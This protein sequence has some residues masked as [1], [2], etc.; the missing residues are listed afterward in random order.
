MAS[1]IRG[2]RSAEA[3]AGHPR[4]AAVRPP[5]PAR[6]TVIIAGNGLE[7]QNRAASELPLDATR[8]TDDGHPPPLIHSGRRARRLHAVSSRVRG[9]PSRRRTSGQGITADQW[10]RV[11][12]YLNDHR[13]ELT[14]A[15]AELY[16]GVDRVAPTPLQSPADWRLSAPVSLTDVSLRWDPTAPP[17]RVDGTEPQSQAVRPVASGGRRLVDYAEALAELDPP[18]L[19]ENRTCYRLTGVSLR[20]GARLT[21]GVSTYFAGLS[22]GEAAAHEFAAWHM[23]R[24]ARPRLADLPFRDLAGHPADLAGRA[25]NP[26]ISMLTLRRERDGRSTFLLHHRDAAQVAHGGGLYQVIPVGVFQPSRDTSAALRADFDLWRCAAR[27]Y[28][29]ELLGGAETY[30]EGGEGSAAF[31]YEAWPFYRSLASARAAGMIRSYLLGL[32]VDPLSLATDILAVTVIDG[33]AFDE[34]FAALAARNAEGAIA[35]GAGGATGFAFT[36]AN[37]ERF[38]GREPMQAAG[39]AVLTLAW[40]YRG[41]LTTGQQ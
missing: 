41:Q 2:S 35:G 10:R 7:D 25:V 5:P 11:R 20:G 14:S 31:D 6:R 32:G 9:V 26:A 12:R 21:F 17:A 15:A 8:N 13:Y 34:I 36:Q 28:S 19:L 24:P 22:V 40:R 29:E 1:R 37:V 23:N 38:A 27:E 16:P 39:A 18:R 3:A 4:A 30:G 33:A